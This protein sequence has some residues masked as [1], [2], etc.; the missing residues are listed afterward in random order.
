MDRRA[1]FL[2]FDACHPDATALTEQARGF[3][4]LD[5]IVFLEPRLSND[6]SRLLFCSTPLAYSS[7]P[8]SW[9]AGYRINIHHKN[10]ET[11]HG[12]DLC[13]YGHAAKSWI[14]TGT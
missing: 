7:R 9:L 10:T 13:R 2:S 4:L 1:T 14:G 6:S 12:R 3:S 5:S 11:T 8:L